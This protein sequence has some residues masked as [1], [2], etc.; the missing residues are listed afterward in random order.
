MT[1]HVDMATPYVEGHRFTRLETWNHQPGLWIVTILSFAYAFITLLIRYSIRRKLTRA[2][3]VLWAGFALA[4]VSY[5]LM[6][7]ALRHGAGQAPEALSD[8]SFATSAKVGPVSTLRKRQRHIADRVQLVSASITFLLLACGCTTSSQLCQ[9]EELVPGTTDKMLCWMGIAI[10]IFCSISTP[11]SV[12]AGC[13]SSKVLSAG[14][15][16]CSG[17]VRDVSPIV[18]R[19]G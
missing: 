3:Y 11:I 18:A 9:L 17:A 19:T 12:S 6:L 1:A 7:N 4:L 14:S 8:G 5:A 13:S 2:D 10:C 15:D 16:Q